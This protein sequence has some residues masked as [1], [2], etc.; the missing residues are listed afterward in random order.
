MCRWRAGLGQNMLASFSSR[1]DVVPTIHCVTP[2]AAGTA[3][4]VR[5]GRFKL[6][7]MASAMTLLPGQLPRCC[8]ADAASVLKQP[9]ESPQDSTK[10]LQI[11][12]IA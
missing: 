3:R 12:R 4:R 9:H 2:L 11:C 8:C 6:N 7:V 1:R 5:E 10:L